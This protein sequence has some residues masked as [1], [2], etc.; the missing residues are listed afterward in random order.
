MA[1]SLILTDDHSTL[2]VALTVQGAS[3]GC[4][5]AAESSCISIKAAPLR[6]AGAGHSG[7][8]L[9]RPGRA[10]VPTP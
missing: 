3:P 2:A 10:P 8:C 4:E 5:L 7:L 6:G 1:K 9:G